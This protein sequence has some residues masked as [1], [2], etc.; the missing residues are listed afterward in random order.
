MQ[1]GSTSCGTSTNS[2]T[3][4]E[5]EGGDDDSPTTNG[6]KRV[7]YRSPYSSRIKRESRSGSSGHVVVDPLQM[8][9]ITCSDEEALIKFY[10]RIL[11][12]AQQDMSK[13]I[14][15]WWIK[16][17][18][19]NKQSK[20]PYAR[21]PGAAPPWW[22]ETPPASALGDVP[23]GNAENG[24]VRHV[25]PDHLSKPGKERFQYYDVSNHSNGGQRD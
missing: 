6:R 3:P 19:P 9:G 16:A 21:G 24:Y 12:D 15:K 4:S 25:E 22:P 17:I 14:A 10:R 13:K 11:N 5:T 2:R 7:R 23:K 20:Y 18:N 1:R 8:I